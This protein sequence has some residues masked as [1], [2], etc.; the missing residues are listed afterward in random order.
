MD[1]LIP[2]LCIGGGGDIPP[3]GGGQPPEDTNGTNGG[4]SN[5]EIPP[6][7]TPPATPPTTTPAGEPTSIDPAL[8]NLIEQHGGDINKLAKKAQSTDAE[9][10]QL[11]T[12]SVKSFVDIV[13]SNPD[14]I[15]IVP[16]SL[17]DAVTSQVY[18]S[19]GIN[20]YQELQARVGGSQ[21]PQ[22][23]FEN[24]RKNAYIKDQFD[25]FASEMKLGQDANDTA[26]VAQQKATK[27]SELMTSLVPAATGLLAS[28]SSL[29][30]N[31][32]DMKN[33]LRV[34]YYATADGQSQLRK[35]GLAEGLAAGLNRSAADISL[36]GGQPTPSD[37][38]Q[39]R[40]EWMKAQR[41]TLKP[42]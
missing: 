37:K 12:S 34:A 16:E 38:P 39:S 30:G 15:S 23:H 2:N 10:G 7:N 3:A 17:R 42:L 22:D 40:I 27:R 21:G 8:K 25:G 28:G 31:N 20:S 6:G 29:L 36:A 26:E 4:D 1:L 41:H 18:G 35:I 13:K 33:A 5:G 19:V 14:Q 24:S 9:Y 32:L 11:R